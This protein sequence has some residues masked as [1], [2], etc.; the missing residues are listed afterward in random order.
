LLVRPFKQLEMERK[1]KII[2]KKN[3][4]QVLKSKIHNF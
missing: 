3:I 4:F 2:D 1:N